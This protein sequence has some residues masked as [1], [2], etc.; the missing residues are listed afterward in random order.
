MFFKVSNASKLAFHALVGICNDLGFRFID[1]QV[2]TDHLYSLGARPV[3]RRKYLSML[4]TA[5]KAETRPGPWH[6]I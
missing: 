5:L 1:C 2:E 6:I 3:T 4:K